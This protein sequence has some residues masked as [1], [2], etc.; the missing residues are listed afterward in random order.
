MSCAAQSPAPRREPIQRKARPDCQER[1]TLVFAHSRAG[2]EQAA[3]PWLSSHC[4]HQAPPGPQ[5]LTSHSGECPG[6]FR[7]LHWESFMNV[8]GEVRGLTETILRTGQHPLP[9]HHPDPWNM[10]S[11][12]NKPTG[13]PASLL[14][15][16]P[17]AYPRI[18]VPDKVP[19][20]SLALQAL[21]VPSCPIQTTPWPLL[22]VSLDCP[23][24]TAPLVVY[25]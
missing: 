19:V 5:T 18:T 15:P 9:P 23:S 6:V 1:K 20:P 16:F 24:M 10:S 22:Q 14:V 13:L 3:P 25:V 2:S 7:C 17:N 11:G 12:G 8:L 4:D 21:P